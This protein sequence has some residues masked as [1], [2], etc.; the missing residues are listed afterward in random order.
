[1]DILSDAFIEYRQA[2]WAPLLR[3]SGDVV[4][5]DLDKTMTTGA[6]EPTGQELADRREAR[7]CM[8][9]MKAVTAGVSARTLGLMMSSKELRAAQQKG[10]TTPEPRW[11]VDPVTGQRIFVP[12][13]KDPFFDDCCDFHMHGSLGDDIA[14]LQDDG[15]AVDREYS[16]LVQFGYKQWR[17]QKAQWL[18]RRALVFHPCESSNQRQ[19]DQRQYEALLKGQETR[20]LPWRVAALTLMYEVLHDIK[21]NMVEIEFKENYDQGKANVFPLKARIQLHFAGRAGHERMLK[22]LEGISERADEGDPLASRLVAVDESKVFADQESNLYV[23][24]LMPRWAQKVFMAKRM[25]RGA[26]IASGRPP[27]SLRFFYADDALTGLPICLKGPGKNVPSASLLPTGSPLAPFLI[28][29]RPCYG[30]QSLEH[31]WKTGAREDIKLRP[32]KGERG[33]YKVHLP[34]R[35]NLPNVFVIGDERYGGM[36]PPGSVAAFLHEFAEGNHPLTKRRS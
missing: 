28:E 33:V 6:P 30:T 35:R 1:M 14:V 29:R 2:S 9:R 4:M 32:V 13:E 17:E 23:V 22:L 18:E 11:G 36:T 10:Y 5:T 8:T 26:A 19:L 27:E 12:I 16:E 24:Y 7:Q 34:G 15:Y 31:L 3:A 20:A 21:E 25:F